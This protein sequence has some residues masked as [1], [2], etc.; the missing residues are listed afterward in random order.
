M[1]KKQK[2]KIP[3][4]S[5]KQIVYNEIYKLMGKSGQKILETMAKKNAVVIEK[6]SPSLKDSF[7]TSN[8][9]ENEI[10]K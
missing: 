1:H 7:E 3:Q 4:D 8:K 6:P 9:K 2:S 10:A 5:T